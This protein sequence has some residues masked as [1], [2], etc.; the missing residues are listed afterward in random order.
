MRSHAVLLAAL[1]LAGA[2]AAA[3]AYSCDPATCKAPACMCPSTKTPGGLAPADTPQF[4]LITHDDSVNALQNRLVRTMTDGFKNPN[5]CNV[6]ATWF[7]LKD[8]TNCTLVQQLLKDNHEIA[9]HTMNH[10]PLYKNLTV[11]Q[12]KEEVEGIKTW[13]VE[14]CG[15][16]EAEFKG[17]RAPYLIH[18]EQYRKVMA[19]AN[20][21]YDSSIIEP[22]P[23]ATSPSFA[24]RTWPF[25]MDAGIPLD[26]AWA[27]SADVSCSETERYPGVWEVPLWILPD[28]AGTS[29]AGFS[30]DPTAAT[31]DALFGLLKK[32]FDAAYDGNRAPFPLFVH[33]PWFTF[34]NTKAAIQFVEYANSK[35]DVWFVT[36]SQLMD[37]MKN[38]VP[39]SQMNSSQAVTCK[40]L[41]ELTPPTDEYCRQ[42]KVGPVEDIWTVGGK[43]GIATDTDLEEL[44]PKVNKWNIPEGTIMNMPP[45]D[46]RCDKPGAT[47]F[48][49]TEWYKPVY[50]ERALSPV[51]APASAP[52]PAPEVDVAPTPSPAAAAVLSPS[53]APTPARVP[54]PAPA[55]ASGAAAAASA[56]FAALA[57]LASLALLL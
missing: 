42:Y 16:P 47:F 15:V 13:M 29:A 3:A 2:S 38:P 52:A 44:N 35:P 6:P 41:V 25:T 43:F 34:D 32:S 8:K 5:G 14:E 37:W 55:P 1:L 21:T 11:E 54:T 57:G 28:E 33:A 18:N 40:T 48:P 46:A 9:G 39:A 56:A 20:Y 53:P 26:C 12:V 50:T 36:M 51:S 4:V 24:E 49:D 31:P 7:A 17:F 45:W 23:T 22:F 19:A 27:G 10:V 30:M